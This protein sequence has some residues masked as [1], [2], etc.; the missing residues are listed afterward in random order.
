[1]KL[2]FVIDSFGPGGAQRQMT[3][4]AEEL[5]GRGH[6]ISFF[7]YYPEHREFAPKNIPVHAAPKKSRWSL[8]PLF[9]LR[10]LIRN[11][12]FDGVLAYLQT[13]GFYAELACAGLKDVVLVV[14]ERSSF[15]PGRAPLAARILRWGHCLAD[16]VVVNSHHHRK[17]LQKAF[18][19]M[20]GRLRTIENGI[21]VQNYTESPYPE[22]SKGEVSLLALGRVDRLKNPL[23]LIQAMGILKSSGAS[24]SRIRWAGDIPR[25]SE[26]AD[27]YTQCNVLLERHGIS[28]RWEWLGVRQ[29]VPALIASSDGLIHPSLLEGASNAVCEAMAMGRPVLAGRIGDHEHL[30]HHEKTGILFDPLVAS[31][32]GRAM[33]TFMEIDRVDR[34]KMGA[35]AAAFVRETMSISKCAD[36]Y[37]EV[38]TE[39]RSRRRQR[40]H[41]NV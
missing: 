7:A 1:M 33:S 41:D 3:A 39:C 37:E 10:R 9:E 8:G 34:G 40:K 20:S 31:D 32:I 25:T 14:S 27:Y 17:R 15:P 28:D 38:F 2:L 26:G 35:R 30:I 21:N 13:P 29:D 19:W 18:P 6:S 22:G 11:H 4:L 12:Q 36:R 16:A 5:S 23:G 24:L